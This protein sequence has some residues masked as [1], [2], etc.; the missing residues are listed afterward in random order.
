MS[1]PALVDPLSN[2]REVI[3][4]LWIRVWIT[5]NKAAVLGIIVLIHKGLDFAA[6][7]VIPAGWELVSV[8]LRG[9]FFAAFSVVYLHFVWEVLVIF[10][11]AV[12]RRRQKSR[13]SGNATAAATSQ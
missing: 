2:W 12:G 13:E 6:T 3:R 10:V 9:T 5:V 7:W 1:D 8:I 11:P 4:H